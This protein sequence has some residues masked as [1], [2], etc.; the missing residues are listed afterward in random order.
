[1]VPALLENLL[2]QEKYEDNEEG[3]GLNIVDSTKSCLTSVCEAIKD[4]FL[5]YAKVFVGGS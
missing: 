1:L 4:K 5:D 2:D 3:G